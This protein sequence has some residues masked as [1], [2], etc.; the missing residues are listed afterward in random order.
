MV[1]YSIFS[2]WIFPVLAQD[3]PTS[4]RLVFLL[5]IFEIM[6]PM[7]STIR[8][9]VLQDDFGFPLPGGSGDDEGQHGVRPDSVERITSLNTTG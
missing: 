8:A 7:L 1:W 6:S 5:E 9:A 2:W 3:L 4:G